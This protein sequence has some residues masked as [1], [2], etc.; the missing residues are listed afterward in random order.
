METTYIKYNLIIVHKIYTHTRFCVRVRVRREDICNIKIYKE[1]KLTLRARPLLMF[2]IQIKL[3]HTCNKSRI[4]NQEL[5]TLIT[6]AT[7]PAL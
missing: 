7:I 3:S 4:S 6:N 5:Y 2:E 1:I